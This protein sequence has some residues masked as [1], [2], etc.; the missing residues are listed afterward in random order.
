MNPMTKLP[1][2]GLGD[3]RSATDGSVTIACLLAMFV[4]LSTG[5]ASLTVLCSRQAAA[6]RAIEVDQAYLEAEAAADLA[7][8][9]VRATDDFAAD[10]IGVVTGTAGRG[11]FTTTMQPA[12]AGNGTYTIVAT[13]T[14]GSTSRTID[15][16]I[17]QGGNGLGFAGYNGISMSGGLV[18]TYDS[19]LG[20]YASQ[21]VGGHA[22]NDVTVASNGNISLSGGAQIWGDAKPGP[23][24]TV[25]GAVG[26]H[27]SS[28]PASSLITVPTYTYSPPIAAAGAFSGNAAFA[29]GTYRYTTFTV[30]NGKHVT[31]SGDV[32]LYV[33]G[34]FTVFG[35]GYGTLLP[36][37][38]LT[39]HHGS[40]SFTISGGGVVNQD[41]LPS[42]L[43]VNSATTSNVTCSGSSAFYG[44]FNCPQ[45]PLVASGGAGIYGAAC[46]KT[47]TLSS[48][49]SLHYDRQ[50]GSGS[51][52][53]VRLIRPLGGTA[54]RA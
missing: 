29:A 47:M 23:S 38:H 27:G 44:T 21:V 13:G 52:L 32:T 18:D 9:E 48:G 5:L 40:G 1:A 6:V 50:L 51:G 26:V 36:G 54:H 14:V 42:K 17:V 43:T 15:V 8:A 28:A 30:G 16:T 39:I 12:F 49:M 46:A 3:R 4:V 34:N 53:A 11:S 24:G 20:T 45:A 37:A 25:S 33:D 7:I 10:G 19:A 2:S 22:G 41:Q 35:S 31:F